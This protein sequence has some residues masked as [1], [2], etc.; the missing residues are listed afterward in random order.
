MN[1]SSFPPCPG[2]GTTPT[3]HAESCSG[4]PAPRKAG[5]GEQQGRVRPESRK[6][7]ARQ[8]S[9]SATHRLS[10]PR[11]GRRCSVGPIR[12]SRA[13]TMKMPPSRAV[14]A[15]QGHDREGYFFLPWV[16][17]AR[18]SG[19]ISGVQTSTD[20][21][22]SF[23]DG[24][25]RPLAGDLGGSTGVPVGPCSELRTRPSAGPKPTLAAQLPGRARRGGLRPHDL[26]QRAELAHTSKKSTR[27]DR[28]SSCRSAAAPPMV[29]PRSGSFLSS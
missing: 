4:S 15:A 8:D 21:R 14:C 26:R 3:G 25:C 17:T 27:G 1:P 19:L 20:L 9:G 13:Q 18:L 22:S 29:A 23:V 11:H 16:S 12:T 10:P 24:R 2:P 5:T 28:C 6:G 7:A